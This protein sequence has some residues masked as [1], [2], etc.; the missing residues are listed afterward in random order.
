MAKQLAYGTSTPDSY[1]R[2]TALGMRVFELS[3]TFLI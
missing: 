1:V 3:D 2:P